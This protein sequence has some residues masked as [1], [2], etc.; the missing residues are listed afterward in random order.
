MSRMSSS[1]LR[2]EEERI[3]RQIA[4]ERQR[5]RE[6]NRELQRTQ[7]EAEL[8]AKRLRACWCGLDHL[9]GER[10]FPAARAPRLEITGRPV[11][12]LFVGNLPFR[13][14]P[15]TLEKVLRSL[16]DHQF[17]VQF[18][19][20]HNRSHRGTAFLSFVSPDRAREAIAAIDGHQIGGRTIRAAFAQGRRK[21]DQRQVE[22]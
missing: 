20:D 12:R 9:T 10:L 1:A 18:L 2:E 11:S 14:A 22:A 7:A 21:H 8:R 4:E 19:L 13:E 17:S 3:R 6:H 5:E 16:F 15:D